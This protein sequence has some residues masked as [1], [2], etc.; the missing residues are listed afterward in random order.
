MRIILPPGMWHEVGINNLGY[1]YLGNQ[2]FQIAV[3]VFSDNVKAHPESSNCYD[4]LGEAH[5]E[6]G[7]RDKAIANYQRSL[8]LDP[9]NDNAKLMIKK[10]RKVGG[11]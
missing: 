8:E 1:R 10:L 6:A 7:N 4:S 2:H 9:S 3:A 11:N 5:M